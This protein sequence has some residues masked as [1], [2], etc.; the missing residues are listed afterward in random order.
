MPRSTQPING[1]AHIETQYFLEKLSWLTYREWIVE[2]V[3]RVE[4][5]RPVRRPLK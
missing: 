3:P 4:V 5:E 1:I 2:E